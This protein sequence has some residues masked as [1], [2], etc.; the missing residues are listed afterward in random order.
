MQPLQKPCMGEFE[1]SI[2]KSNAL[3]LDEAIHAHNITRSYFIPRI[4]INLIFNTIFS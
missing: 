2:E 3:Q 1:L 4:S